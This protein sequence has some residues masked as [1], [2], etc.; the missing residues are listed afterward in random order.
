MSRPLERIRIIDLSWVLSGPYTTMV[1]ND[2]GAEVIKIERPGIGDIAR[3]NGPFIDGISS[4]FLSLN[5]GKKSITLDLTSETG[6]EIFLKLVAK[7]DVVVENFVP[8]TMERLGLGYDLLRKRNPKIIYATI[9]G[10]GQTGPEAKKPALDVTIQARGGIMSLT[11][12]PGGPPIR[13]GASFGDII[14]GL[15]ACIGILSALIERDKSDE[16]Q[17]IDMSMLD[18][19]VAVMENAFER[20]FATGEVPKALGTRHP[21]FTPFQVFETKD[22]YIALAIVGHQWPLFCANIDHIELIDDARFETGELRTQNY[23]LLEPILTE[24]MK[25]R[26]TQEWLEEFEKV[27]IPCAPVNTVDKVAIDPQILAREMIVE[28]LQPGVGKVKVVNTPIKLSRTVCRAEGACPELGQ[29]TEE[30][31]ASLLG[32]SQNELNRLK[33]Q[34]VI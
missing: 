3:G 34:K 27:E 17:L 30:V 15:F 26:T 2:L 6:K 8:G 23:S 33:E 10:F 24:A 13:P 18:C 9:S 7:A 1:L 5:R 21:I 25:T 19:Q 29:H 32:V 20:Y 4:Y 31:L 14:A 28:I 16:G 11:G 22:N 12:E